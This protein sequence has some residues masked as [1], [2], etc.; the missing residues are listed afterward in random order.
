MIYALAAIS[1]MISIPLWTRLSSHFE[2]YKI[3]AIG[4]G[5][6][7]LLLT[8]RLFIPPGPQGLPWVLGL[9]LVS[10][11]ANAASQVPQMA[12]LA[13]CIDYDTLKTRANRAGLYY[14]IQ[15]FV[16]KTA[17]AAGGGMAFLALGLIK[18]DA[19]AVPHSRAS[20]DGLAAV[21]TFGPLI[22]FLAAG[23]LLWFFPIDQKRQSII[24]RRIESR[25][26]ALQPV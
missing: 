8:L 2:R 5:A 7:G 12:V 9:V 17:L 18:F 26:E 6:F 19:K 10:G 14:A 13:D 1:Q 11:F 23:V 15:Q 20:L 24:R 3:W 21:H 25:T 22:L 4:I 16:L